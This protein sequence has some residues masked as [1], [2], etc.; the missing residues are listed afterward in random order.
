MSPSCTLFQGVEESRLPELYQ[1]LGAV[2]RHYARQE[3]ILLAGD[4]AGAV[5][6]VLSGGVQVLMEDFW[7]NRSILTRIGPGE[8][9]GEVFCCAQTDRLPVSVEAAQPSEVLLIDYRRVLDSD[10]AGGP[11]HPLLIRNMMRILAQK[12]LMLTGK[13]EHLTKRTIREKVLSY[14][15]D[16]AVR[17]GSSLVE[18]SFDRQGLADYLSV[19][20]SALSRELSLMRSQGL[21]RYRR[22]QFRLLTHPQLPGDMPTHL[23]ND[24]E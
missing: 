11:F 19:D 13:M 9:F 22:N 15:S 18:I 6:V 21:L 10:G 24:N 20:R 14:L 3:M 16:Q 5:G 4:P 1:T 8:I 23:F 2:R 7:G 17:Q 12:N